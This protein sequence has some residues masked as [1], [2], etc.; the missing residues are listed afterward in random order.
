M[1]NIIDVADEDEEEYTLGKN[2]E[3]DYKLSVM[4]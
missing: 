4:K 2:L 3:G 1:L